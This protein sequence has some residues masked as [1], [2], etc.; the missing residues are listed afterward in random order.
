MAHLDPVVKSE[1]FD[2][3]WFVLGSKEILIGFY[4]LCRPNLIVTGHLNPLLVWKPNLKFLKTDCLFLSKRAILKVLYNFS[5]EFGKIVRGL[6]V[7]DL[8]IDEKTRGKIVDAIS[9]QKQLRAATELSSFA[10]KI[11]RELPGC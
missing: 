8:C 7:D 10:S 4:A 5:E 11:L 9:A 3:F 1:M 2:S 6:P